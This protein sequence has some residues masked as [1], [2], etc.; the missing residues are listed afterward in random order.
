MPTTMQFYPHSRAVQLRHALK[1]GNVRGLVRLATLSGWP[2]T[3]SELARV[4]TDTMS[5]SEP[6]VLHF[7]GHSWEVD[8]NDL[9]ADLQRLLQLMDLVEVD[10][11]TNSGVV[12]RLGLAE[13]AT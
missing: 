7:W 11:L 2:G 8:S 3:P 10:H 1:E 9:W 5:P 12:N 13:V 4:F 6:A